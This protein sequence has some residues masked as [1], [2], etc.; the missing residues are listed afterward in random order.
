MSLRK[1]IESLPDDRA[2]VLATR[3]V[4]AFFNAHPNEWANSARI[5]RATGVDETHVAV[6][7]QVMA[8]QFVLD[9][10][11]SNGRECRYAPDSLLAIEVRRYLQSS[12]V[13]GARLQRDV[14]RFRGR[15]G[16][17]SR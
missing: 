5:A 10:G 14:D 9:C 4:I 13:S 16:G 8:E 6:V 1:A 3:Q 2:T 11:G 17:T 15:F 7:L 12:A